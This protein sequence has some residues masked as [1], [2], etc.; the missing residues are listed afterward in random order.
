MLAAVFNLNGRAAYA[1]WHFFQMS[2][3]NVIV[4]VVMLAL[5]VAA[6]LVPFPGSKHRS[7][8]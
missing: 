5:F 3:P 1:H 4:I 7:G 2:V 6:L 8:R